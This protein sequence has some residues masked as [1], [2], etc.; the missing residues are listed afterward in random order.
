MNMVHLSKDLKTV[1]VPDLL[2]FQLTA[3]TSLFP[4]THMWAEDPLQDPGSSSYADA[5]DELLALKTFCFL[6]KG[7]GGG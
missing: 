5:T 6:F 1:L 2:Q 7:G 4:A 3:E